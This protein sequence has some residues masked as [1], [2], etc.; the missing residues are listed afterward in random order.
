MRNT[1]SRTSALPALAVDEASLDTE[2][3]SD[4]ASDTG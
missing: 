4:D 2:W 3:S 1:I